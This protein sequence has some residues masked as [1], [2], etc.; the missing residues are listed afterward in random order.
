MTVESK[1]HAMLVGTISLS[2]TNE[3]NDCIAPRHTHNLSNNASDGLYC[4]RVDS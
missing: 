2:R 3:A 4:G 1:C